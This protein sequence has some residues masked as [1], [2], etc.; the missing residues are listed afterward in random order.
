MEDVQDER[1]EIRPVATGRTAPAWAGGAV[2]AVADAEVA[3]LL[4]DT[5]QGLVTYANPA[6]LAM[7]GGRA[8]LPV[9]AG[10]WSAAARL[11][12]PA[13]R[14]DGSHAPPAV[15]PVS[16]VSAGGTI[17]GMRIEIAGD[18]GEQHA[19]WVTGSQLLSASN[20]AGSRA[21]V[22]LFPVNA[23]EI[24]AR[25]GLSPVRHEHP[26]GALAGADGAAIVRADP[27]ARDLVADETRREA[28]AGTLPEAGDL[29][30]LTARALV[31][32]EVSFTISDPRRPDDPLVWVNPAFELMTGYEA[33][34]AIGRNCRFLQGPG[35]DR[36]AVAQVREALQRGEAVRAR[37]AELPQGRH[38]V[39][40]R[41]HDLPRGRR[42]RGADA[43]RRR[44]DRHH[45]PRHRR[46]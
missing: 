34:D 8:S 30:E 1:Q 31:A 28:D 32:S 19:Y 10:A 13:G 45:L 44:P 6:A 20:V 7:T 17:H 26:G 24:T 46:H 27:V 3:V 18:D 5:R 11:V 15:D 12:L 22:A 4:L 25:A 35:T 2:R 14:R 42:R 40:E 41:L 21:I 39:L 43:L 36:E 37:A 38:P 33:D 23:P 29:D 16:V 9:G